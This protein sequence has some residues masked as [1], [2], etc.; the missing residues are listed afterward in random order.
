MKT[1]LL[2]SI[3]FM[4]SCVLASAQGYKRPDSYNYQRGLEA[5]SENNSQEALEYLNR[6]ISEN[7][8]NGYAY[9]WIAM[10]RLD[11]EE[12][13]KAL[14]AVNQAIK[15]LPKKDWEFVI[16]AYTTRA[17]VYLNLEDTVRALEDYTTAIKKKPDQPSLYE[18]RA[19]LY[20]ELENYELSDADYR[21]MIELSPGETMGYMGVGRN[22][23]AQKRWD[24]AIS[25]FDYVIRLDGEYSSGYAFRAEAYLGQEKWNEAT[26]DII[27]SLSKEWDRKA[28]YLAI[29]LK[30][31]ALSM[32]LSKM[33]VQAAKSPNENNWSYIMGNMYEQNHMYEKAI[34]SYLEANRRD[35]SPVILNRMSICQS[36]IG[37]FVQALASINQAINMDSTDLNYNVRKA[38][39]LYEMG[40]ATSSIAE[41]DK[42]LAAVPEYAFGYY[43]RG[44]V[45]DVMGDREAAI[46]DYTT[47]I[48]LDPEESTALACRGYC[49]LRQGKRNLSE[50]DFR[51][52]IELENTPEKY[53]SIHYAY[54]GLGMNDKAIE[55]MD[56]IIAMSDDRAG[57]LYD[58]ACLY[59]RMGNKEKALEYLEE[60]LKKG[61]CRFAH[62]QHDY[63][64]DLLR[65]TD[66]YKALIDRYS[67]NSSDNC[68]AEVV[69][70]VSVPD[71]SSFVPIAEIPF[72]KENGVY[73]VRCNING[74]PL[75]FV[76]DTGASDVT[77]S[78]VEANFMMKNGY[79]TSNDVVGSQRYMDANGDI[80]VGTAIN[81]RNVEFCGQHLENVRASVVRNQNAPLLLGQSV[82]GRLGRIEINNQ[83]QV[84]TIK[85]QR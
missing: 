29:N 58:A 42:V 62:M 61:Y 48:V 4:L 65:E 22:A 52:V 9:S 66:E 2:L 35:A 51:R 64:M 79:L 28:I 21:K 38:E 50:A 45:K 60:A 40:D 47:C 31:P 70:A 11:N 49:Y 27:S 32:L 26:D 67:T 73:K 57:N 43:R 54:Q 10:L 75:H 12:Y 85:A 25:Q 68:D 7:P 53:Q 36:E 41:L 74:L 24:E 55:A 80:T 33:R 8:K 16:F 76:F 72:T 5:I 23:N 37:R 56:S 6:D 19:Q 69:G 30:E 83:Q 82:L 3:C 17:G 14:T 63:D 1:K 15:Y 71:T 59:S 81:L 18:K 44:W 34:E 46:E 78:L 20:Y 13:G 77:I 84:L 39:I